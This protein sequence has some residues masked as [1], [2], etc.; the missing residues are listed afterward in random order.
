[1]TAPAPL[2][3]P[4]VILAVV[5]LL[6]LLGYGVVTEGDYRVIIALALAVLIV[7]GADVGAVLR[8]WRGTEAAPGTSPPDLTKRQEPGS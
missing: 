7:L 3:R 1:M 6:G 4:A 8:S 5:V 2:P